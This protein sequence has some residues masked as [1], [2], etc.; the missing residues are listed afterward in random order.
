MPISLWLFHLL[1]LSNRGLVAFLATH[2]THNL[3]QRTPSQEPQS[4]QRRETSTQE[5]LVFGLR[6]Q[7]PGFH[8]ITF[9]LQRIH[10]TRS[11]WTLINNQTKHYHSNANP[12]Y[13]SSFSSQ[14]ISSYI[15]ALVSNQEIPR[16]TTSTRPDANFRAF[17]N[18]S[19]L[20][21]QAVKIL[22]SFTG[23]WQQFD[24]LFNF[25]SLKPR[26]KI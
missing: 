15:R 16:C 13:D 22:G 20:W 18:W 23:P 24:H 14:A 21:Q 1:L 12:F 11:F 26:K 10:Q 19:W 25:F 2:R 5:H 9:H 3:R 7:I 4:W 8:Q 6:D 17:K